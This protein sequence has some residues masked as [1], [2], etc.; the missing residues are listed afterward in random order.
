VNKDVPLAVRRESGHTL[1]EA[2]FPAAMVE[3]LAL[4]AGSDFRFRVQVADVDNGGPKHELSLSP[5]GDWASGIKI[6]L[7]K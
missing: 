1:Y 2:A 4:K 6:V 3:P 7:G 5:G